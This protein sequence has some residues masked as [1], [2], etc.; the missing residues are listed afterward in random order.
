MIPLA[1]ANNIGQMPKQFLTMAVVDPPS[2]ANRGGQKFAQ[3]E[4]MEKSR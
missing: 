3:P 1:I 4:V 2:V